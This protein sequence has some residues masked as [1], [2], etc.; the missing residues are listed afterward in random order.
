MR[1]GFTRHARERCRE[2]GIK[3]GDVKSVITD[4][5]RLTA[6]ESKTEARKRIR[7]RTLIVIF[8]AERELK[9]IITAYY[10]D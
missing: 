2:R 4:P 1:S 3:Y 6:I 10:E 7:N 5:D 9:K 8:E